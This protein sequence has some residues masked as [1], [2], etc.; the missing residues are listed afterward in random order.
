MTTQLDPVTQIGKPKPPRKTFSQRRAERN[1]GPKI[2]L[3]TKVLTRIVLVVAAVYFIFPVWWLIMSTT[4]TKNELYSTNGM[5]FGEGMHIFD[6]LSRAM[7]YDQGLYLRWVGNSLL[8]SGTAMI[9]GVLISVA[10]GYALAK[11][12]FPGRNVVTVVI[13]GGLLIPAAL[14]T[15]PLYFFFNSIGLVDTM[16][17]VIIPSC[18]SPFGVFL[19]R[20]YADI[21]VPTELLE[22]ARMDGAGEFRIFFTMVLRIL[23]PALVTIG[24]F[25]FVAT[26]NNFLL[27]LVMLNSSELYPVTL[28]LYTW[29]SYRAVDLTDLVLVGSLFAVI[30]L[31]VAF[32][33]LQRFWQSG[34]AMGSV[35]G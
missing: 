3:T 23:K 9:I 6:N 26:W 27:P 10:A 11:F 24:L 7:N 18:V 16:W 15:I 2:P 4:K 30:P 25:I 20:I 8:Y 29:Q 31:V 1:M 13:L 5:W 35:K 12:V 22:A 32:I 21:S 17:A 19:G 33:G 28:G 34:L 14:L